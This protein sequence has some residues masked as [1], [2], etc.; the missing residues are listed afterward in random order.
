[1]GTVPSGSDGLEVWGGGNSENAPDKRGSFVPP[2]H[3]VC[4]SKLN[5]RSLMS[6]SHAEYCWVVSGRRSPGKKRYFLAPVSHAVMK[7]R[8]VELKA[9]SSST[10]QP[11]T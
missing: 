5:T 11:V 1:M 6:D 9:D 10:T 7:D 4:V 2:G 8:P 3:R